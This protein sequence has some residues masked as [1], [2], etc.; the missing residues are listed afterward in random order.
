MAAKYWVQY[1]EAIVYR[2]SNTVAHADIACNVTLD[3]LNRFWSDERKLSNQ[4]LLLL[5]LS[6]RRLTLRFH[7]QHGDLAGIENIKRPFQNAL[8]RV[9]PDCDL[10]W[11][12]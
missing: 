7:P 6:G 10:C 8:H 9:R 3:D 4:P 11:L 2:W 1:D 5:D 12:T